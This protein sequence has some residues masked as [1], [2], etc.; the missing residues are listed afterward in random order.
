M[1]GRIKIFIFIGIYLSFLFPLQTYSEIRINEIKIERLD[2]FDTLSGDWFFAAKLA[3]SLHFLTKKFVIIDEIPFNE[4]D[5]VDEHLLLE[6]EKNLRSMNLFSKVDL[7]LDSVDPLNYNITIVTKDRWS[8]N[9]SFLF[10]TGGESYRI[11]ARIE[12]LNFLGYGMTIVPELL[13]R[14]ENNTKLQGKLKFFYRRF[15]RLPISFKYDLFIN[16]FRTLHTIELTKPF[17]NQTTS[18]SF[19]IQLVNHFGNDLYFLPGANYVKM[20]Y[21]EK[22]GTIFYSRS[23]SRKDR[24]FVTGLVDVR[25]QIRGKPEYR[26]AFDNSAK[27]FISF[28]SISENFHKTNRL[29]TFLT[30]DVV[31]GGW[32]SAVLGKTFKIDTNGINSFYLAGVGEK[33]YLSPNEK[34]YLFGR[35]VG[36]SAFAQSNAFN[37]YEEFY[38]LG[39]LRLNPNLLIAGQIRQQNVWN[40][41]GVR[42]LLLDNNHYLRGYTLNELT[43]SN[44][45]ITNLELRYFPDIKF[46]IFYFSGVLFYD[47]GTVW[48]QGMEIIKSKWKN[49]AGFGLRIHNDKT[50]G[51]LGIIRFDFAF[52]LEK[53]KF[54]EIIVSSDQFF[55][56]FKSHQFELPTI[57]GGEY[58]YE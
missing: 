33:S 43:G 49:S 2:V 46:W 14:S 57:Y 39:F 7:Y 12:E 21:Y 31:I 37:T 40:W 22:G 56:I 47:G 1:C 41:S 34:L 5:F 38:G 36:A 23:W 10:G 19:G 16:R 27:I 45:I 52:N 26:Q 35:L 25:R 15:F 8:T 29:N 53:K 48:N 3:N 51:R 20:N 17:Y 50:A 28:S 32:G 42:Q 30:E 55:S 18:K 11:G 54:A 9:P 24:L 44:R 6:L 13:Y 4:G 58:E